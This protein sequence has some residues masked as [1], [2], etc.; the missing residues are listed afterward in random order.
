MLEW[1]YVYT[2]M[3]KSTFWIVQVIVL[4]TSLRDQNIQRKKMQRCFTYWIHSL[5]VKIGANF[6]TFHAKMVFFFLLH[7]CF[8]PII[9]SHHHPWSNFE[10]FHFIS[11]S[12]H[13]LR[14]MFSFL[15]PNF[16]LF[17]V[18]E[19]MNE[20]QEY[21]ILQFK[22]IIGIFGLWWLC[23]KCSWYFTTFTLW[24]KLCNQVKGGRKKKPKKKKRWITPNN[25]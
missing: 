13:H 25:I 14:F 1:P 7:H 6:M 12:S 5:K 10:H 8:A 17:L 22:W 16:Q 19:M 21:Q 4:V 18:V 24:K 2:Y 20:W 23:T 11:I 3:L 9:L 15:S